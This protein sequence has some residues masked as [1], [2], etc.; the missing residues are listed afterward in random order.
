MAVVPIGAIEMCDVPPPIRWILH[1]G[2]SGH[3]I[4]ETRAAT[5]VV[6]TGEGVEVV[7]LV[8][9]DR[10]VVVL[11]GAAGVD[12]LVVETDP[13]VAGEDEVDVDGS[14]VD[15][16]TAAVVSELGELGVVVEVWASA[17]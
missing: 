9:A 13:V 6:V 14:T 16:E 2:A 17:S 12:V 15:V 10:V 8:V 7:V 11:V 3:R 5:V 4:S 1:P